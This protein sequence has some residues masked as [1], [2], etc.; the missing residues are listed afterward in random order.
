MYFINTTDYLGKLVSWTF[1]IVWCCKI[2]NVSRTGSIPVISHND[3]VT[4]SVRT[5]WRLCGNQ[6]QDGSR[7]E[8]K[9]AAAAENEPPVMQPLARR[10]ICEL[11]GLT[12]NVLYVVSL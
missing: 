5:H 10:Y 12:S 11:S 4:Y 8:D 3:G 2:H 7:G 6:I 1:F 9:I